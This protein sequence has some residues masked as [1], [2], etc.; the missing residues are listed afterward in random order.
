[1]RSAT[2]RAGASTCSSAIIARAHDGDGVTAAT[3]AA[4]VGVHPNVARHHLDKLA[5]GGYIE[6]A[7][8]SDE[9]PRKAGRPSKRYVAV[10]TDTP[11][12]VP[13]HTEDLVLALLGQALARLPQPDAEAMAED[14]GA[15]Y[16]RTLAA[17]LT[18]DAL[19]A[20][21]RSLRSAMQAV[22]AALTAHGFA[23]RTSEPAVV[24][25]RRAID[26]LRIISDHCP[27]GNVA[28]EHPVLCA[29]D[30]GMVRGML[31][32]LYPSAGTLDVVTAASKPT[33]TP[34]APPPSEFRHRKRSLL[35]ELAAAPAF[36]R[37]R[38]PLGE[39]G[40]AKP[41]H[42]QVGAPAQR[43]DVE[44]FVKRVPRAWCG[45]FLGAP[46][47]RSGAWLAAE[48]A[49]GPRGQGGAPAAKRG[50]TTLTPGWRLLRDP[51]ALAS[52]WAA[53]EGAVMR[54]AAGGLAARLMYARWCRRR[55][56]RSWV[57]H[58]LLDG[59]GCGH[60]RHGDRCCC[61]GC[62][63]H[64]GVLAAVQPG[65]GGD[66]RGSCQVAVISAQ[67]NPAS[68]RAMAVTTILRLVLRAS[69]RR[70]LPHRRSCA[71]QA[72]ATTAG[73][74]PCL[75]ACDHR[76]DGGAGLVGPGRLDELGAQVTVAGMGDPA[77]VGTFA[78][79]VLRWGPARRTP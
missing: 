60:S 6:V 35:G 11:N 31:G 45:W 57:P 33:A 65:R 67:T 32:V 64:H 15:T 49:A 13:V 62:P 25:G 22:A 42:L 72:R 70:N 63:A 29:V 16:G 20:G 1:M 75:A 34:S 66:G 37:R 8:R 48:Q 28:I 36:G 2:Q 78:R 17:G 14:V 54:R 51:G 59:G 23:A 56:L 26:G 43:P 46:D 27:F 69:R 74:R 71:V 12:E 55:A 53:V 24:G 21:Q 39:D 5:A 41:D 10:P 4:E 30:R 7:A 52:G 19:D 68:S 3:V 47:R 77:T 58:T 73:S 61:G 50:R 9:S 79:G 40:P 44:R 76:A 18:G 38:K